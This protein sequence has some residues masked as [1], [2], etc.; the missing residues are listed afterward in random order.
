VQAPD[1]ALLVLTDDAD[2]KILRVTPAQR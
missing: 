1:G 2:G